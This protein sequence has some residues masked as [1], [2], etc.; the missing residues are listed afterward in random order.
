LIFSE[1]TT[2]VQ[3]GRA[4]HTCALDQLHRVEDDEGIVLVDRLVRDLVARVEQRLD[5]HGAGRGVVPDE[6]D[7]LEIR[8]ILPD[9][10]D[11]GYSR[12]ST[13]R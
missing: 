2:P 7:R 4:P 9:R 5:R 13:T 8:Q 10:L 12:S 6:E 11:R 3:H 1:W